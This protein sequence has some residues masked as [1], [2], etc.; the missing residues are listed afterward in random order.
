M[1]VEPQVIEPGHLVVI[2]PGSYLTE[3][4]SYQ[5]PAMLLVKQPTL[6]L[7]LRMTSIGNDMNLVQVQDGLCN[8]I[9]VGKSAFV[10]ATMETDT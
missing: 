5:L 8:K 10:S 4:V 7:V 1:Q 2:K 9:L 3:D 6:G